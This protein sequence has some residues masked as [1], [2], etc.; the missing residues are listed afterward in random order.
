MARAS[1]K[2]IP[3]P[4][5]VSLANA[6]DGY[7]F[8]G[9][10]GSVNVIFLPG[11][12]IKAEG[13]DVKLSYTVQPENKAMLG[14]AVALVR[15]AIT[16][17]TEGFSKVITLRGTGFKVQK[18]GSNLTLTLGFSHPVIYAL[19]KGID[20]EIFEPKIRDDKDWIADITVKGIDRQLVGQVAAH[21]RRLRPPDSYKGKG[22]RY[23]NEFV[24]RKL[25]KRAAGAE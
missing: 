12:G 18:E 7:V 5:G 16:G 3:L 20:A 22:L 10:K 14:L 6:E 23:K 15:N 24:R 25:G 2:P 8:K 9:P 17:V 11:I 4:S 13:Q 21:I 19:P 1:L